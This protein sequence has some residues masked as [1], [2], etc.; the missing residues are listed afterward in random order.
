MNARAPALSSSYQLP[1]PAPNAVRCRGPG[2]PSRNTG[3]RFYRGTDFH[4]RILYALRQAPVDELPVEGRA[5]F[6]ARRFE[7]LPGTG[8]V[9]GA[10]VE[11]AQLGG[12]QVG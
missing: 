7:V 5:R 10:A 6:L 4:A 1:R 8:P 9:T 11:L 2:S 12:E 3:D